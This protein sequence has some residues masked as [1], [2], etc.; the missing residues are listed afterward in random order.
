MGS[1]SLNNMYNMYVI[2][3][4]SS[5]YHPVQ[6]MMAVTGQLS[7]GHTPSLLTSPCG[8]PSYRRRGI[9]NLLAKSLGLP[10]SKIVYKW[11]DQTRL[12]MA[13]KTF[14]DFGYE[15]YTH[16]FRIFLFTVF[17]HILPVPHQQC[18]GADGIWFC[19]LQVGTYRNF[20]GSKECGSF[21]VFSQ[22]PWETF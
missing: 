17:H 10:E 21:W 12:L 15:W 3:S 19:T 1:V 9:G 16:H 14:M 18:V 5:K 20:S 2:V 7:Q 13:E 4:R 11:T 8:S 6:R 22:R